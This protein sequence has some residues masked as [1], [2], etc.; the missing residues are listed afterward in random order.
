MLT[1]SACA[2]I[3]LTLEVLGPRADGYHKVRTI[4]QAIDLRDSLTLV[5]GEGISLECD[6]PGLRS[7]D[8]L[9]LRAARLLQQEVGTRRGA[10]VSIKKG[11]PVASGLGGGASDAAA[12]LKGLN[13]LWGLG[14]AT[15]RLVPLAAALGSD[16]AFFL[17]GGTAL[18][19]GRGERITPLPPPLPSWVVLLRPA[20]DV[21][22]N[23]TEGLYQRLDP[24]HFTQGQFTTRVMELL[25]RRG[26]VPGPLLFNAFERIAF[27]VFPGLEEYWQR[28]LALGAED[29]HLAGTGPTLFTVVKDRDP[30]E[31]LYRSLKREGLE[32]YLVHTVATP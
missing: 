11:I 1:V 28:F 12:T 19:E 7:A 22:Q 13:E 29:V 18:G 23:K 27:A 30:G 3:N 15:H 8:N 14:L 20:I 26:E 10:L 4:F 9:A 16:A 25:E 6:E 32:A 17:Y 24:S 2:K 31:R 21:P 5:E